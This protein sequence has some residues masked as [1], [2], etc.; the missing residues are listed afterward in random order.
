[1]LIILIRP[2]KTFYESEIRSTHRQ[3]RV[4]QRFLT[5]DTPYLSKTHDG[6]PQN[7]TFG[8]G[9]VKLYMAITT[10]LH[11]HLSP[12]RTQGYENKT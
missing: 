2:F 12:L 7:F 8:K 9:G 5:C 11:K 3:T 1:M 10:Y 6:T 4:S